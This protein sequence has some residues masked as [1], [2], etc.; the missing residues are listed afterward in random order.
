[1]NEVRV[2]SPYLPESVSGGTPAANERVRKVVRSFGIC[3]NLDFGNAFLV[4]LCYM[5]FTSLIP[6]IVPF[7]SSLRRRDCNLAMAV[8]E[9]ISKNFVEVVS[10]N[11]MKRES[12]TYEVRWSPSLVTPHWMS[13]L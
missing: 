5:P 8:N 7:R 4:V 3:L 6:H 9:E 2:S 10:L 11:L 1:M 12:M 13:K